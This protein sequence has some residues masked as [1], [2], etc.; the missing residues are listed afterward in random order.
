MITTKNLTK[1]QTKQTVYVP[2]NC[3]VCLRHLFE[4]EGVEYESIRRVKADKEAIDYWCNRFKSEAG[5]DH[6]KA[7]MRGM[8]VNFS[9]NDMFDLC[10]ELENNPDARYELNKD[11]IHDGDLSW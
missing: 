7:V 4:K 3:W 1:T 5:I 11:D 2:G 10:V 9:E 8:I 6:P